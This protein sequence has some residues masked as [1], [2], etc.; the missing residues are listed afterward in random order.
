MQS[1]LPVEFDGQD[2]AGVAVVA[3]LRTLLE[4]VDVHAAGHRATNHHHQTAGKEPLHDVGI[5]ALTYRA[6]REE[7]DRQRTGRQVA[8]LLGLE[9]G[10]YYDAT[11]IYSVC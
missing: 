4:V 10:S 8:Y 7:G 9:T 11:V 1:D 5:W 2:V 3:D 6:G